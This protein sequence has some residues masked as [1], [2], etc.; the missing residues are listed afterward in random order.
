MAG[1]TAKVGLL[2]TAFGKLVGVVAAVSIGEMIGNGISSAINNAMPKVAD[3]IAEWRDNSK[4]GSMIKGAASMIGVTTPDD[5]NRHHATDEEKKVDDAATKD[6]QGVNAGADAADKQRQTWVDLVASGEKLVSTYDKVTDKA[7]KLDLAQKQLD[8]LKTVPAAERPATMD[9]AHLTAI[10]KQIDAAREALDPMQKFR[11]D[12]KDALEKAQAITKEQQD[13]LEIEK[14]IGELQGKNP[15]MTDAKED[16]VRASMRQAQ[17][18][19]IQKSY[20]EQMQTIARATQATAALT[21]E[22]KQRLE[23][24]NK[25]ADAVKKEG[26]S[27]EQL[28]GYKQ[29]LQIQQKLNEMTATQDHLD[30]RAKATADYNNQV[31]ILNETLAAGGI[32][33]NKYN[34][35]LTRLNA[36]TL[37]ARDPFAAQVKSIQDEIDK[38]E[39]VG[40]YAEADRLT[41]EQINKLKEQGV[42][43]TKQEA[44]ALQQVNR[45]MQEINKPTNGFGQWAQGI[46]DA[47]GQLVDLEKSFSS[48]LSEAI[49]GALEGKKGNFSKLA[50]SMGEQMTKAGVDMMMKQGMQA[51]GLAPDPKAQAATLAA[52]LAKEKAANAAG[53]AADAAKNVPPAGS[54]LQAATMQVTATT[55]NVNGAQAMSNPQA[56]ANTATPGATSNP[57]LFAQTPAN[58]NSAPTDVNVAAVNGTALTSPAIPFVPPDTGAQIAA[59]TSAM[60]GLPALA[61]GGAMVGAG[62]GLFG[63]GGPNYSA[64][65]STTMGGVPS[66]APDAALQA[67]RPAIR[68]RRSAWHR[69]A[70]CAR[71]WWQSYLTR[72]GGTRRARGLHRHLDD[73]MRQQFGGQQGQLGS[74]F[75]NAVSFGSQQQPGINSFGADAFGNMPRTE[76]AEQ[77]GPV[78]AIDCAPGKLHPGRS[79]G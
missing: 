55:V 38:M 44:D 34:E 43:V 71:L 59:G 65:S 46:K 58:T 61:A 76:P 70:G 73:A 60:S 52:A 75:K 37:D 64:V 22:D 45:T 48:G 19:N 31:R 42:A 10:Q 49:T 51:I 68:L 50:V 79:A 32:S 23:I 33:A 21:E 3:A 1:A 6:S 20:E 9:D 25:I 78:Y 7:Q 14:K 53:Q 36:E 69:A 57:S 13:Q 24:A 5:I 11:D 66:F 41:Q 17:L 47:Q 15:S 77:H 63:I 35:E 16:E 54:M 74:P 12:Q 2:S 29:A 56:G 26:F 27:Q 8:A 72:N 40:K 67:P 39:I 30:P 62:A 4:I 18:A 28:D